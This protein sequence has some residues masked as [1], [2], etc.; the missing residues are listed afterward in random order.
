MSLFSMKLYNVRQYRDD[1]LEGLEATAECVTD[2]LRLVDPMDAPALKMPNVAIKVH[3]EATVHLGFVPSIFGR[4][5]TWLCSDDTDEQDGCVLFE[6]ESARHEKILRNPVSTMT[7]AQSLL[8]FDQYK[9]HGLLDHALST[10]GLVRRSDSRLCQQFIRTGQP[11]VEQVARRMAE[12]RFLFDCTSYNADRNSAFN[13]AVDVARGGDD[14]SEDDDGDDDDDD[15][16]YEY[17]NYGRYRRHRHHS[18]R[19]GYW[20]DRQTVYDRVEKQILA[21]IGGFPANWPWLVSGV[22]V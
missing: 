13:M 19:R 18:R 22:G 21:D 6:E 2:L 3:V 11:N 15:D 7:V 1:H 4:F 12:M 16:D 9:R 20:V 10:L 17:E 8:H 14:K 5:W